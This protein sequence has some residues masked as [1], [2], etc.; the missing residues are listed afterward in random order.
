VT[1]E[2][3]ADALAGMFSTDEGVEDSEGVKNSNKRL[4][5]GKGKRY[6]KKG[7]K[8][9][10][11]EFA[12]VRAAVMA[13]N[14]RQGK[15]N[16]LKP[17]IGVSAYDNY[18]YVCA[19]E[20]LG[21]FYVLARYDVESEL[22]TI[23]EIRKVLDNE[24]D[25]ISEFSALYAKSDVEKWGNNRRRNNL[26]VFSFENGRASETNGRLYAEETEHNEF[27]NLGKNNKIG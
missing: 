8:L 2:F 24:V 15:E 4:T 20:G 14:T 17:I 5:N 11:Q 26:R 25:S 7:I 16:E 21:E 23:K 27:G 9:N 12:M 1:E 19:N 10:N 22:E 18:Y 3:T 13:Y 6:N